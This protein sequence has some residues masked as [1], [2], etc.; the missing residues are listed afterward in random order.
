MEWSVLLKQTFN[1]VSSILF[2]VLIA[3][4][5]TIIFG[6]MRIINMAHGEL[7]MV[8]AYTLHA[9]IAAGYGF[10][11]GLLLAPVVTGLVGILMERSVIRLLYRRKDLSTLLATW[12]FSMVLQQACKLLFGPQPQFI[13]NPFPGSIDV[14]GVT[15]P[16]YRIFSTAVCL[17]VVLGVL[18]IFF[19]SAFGVMARATI[20]NMEMANVLGINT[21]RMFVFA[22]GFGS[23]LAGLS[24]ALIAP[25]VGVIPTMGLDYIARA[26]F[27]VIVGGMG[28]LLG[29][30]GS[31][32]IL[33]GTESFITVA[34]TT[35]V[36]QI[37]VFILVIILMI[38]RP[39]G[40]FSR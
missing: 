13:T 9:T 7:M 1:G 19:R 37:V 33:G 39:K 25:L 28:S 38:L 31:G 14:V 18:C 24:G 6:I 40:L 3:L 35:T 30:I 4:G 21:D 29:A 20:Q 12:G 17:C 8:G 2:L 10:W 22:F 15:Y 36:A 34:S 5:L 32:F 11:T 27:I 23:A 26:F 16:A